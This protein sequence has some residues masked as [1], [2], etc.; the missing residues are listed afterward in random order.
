MATLCRPSM[1]SLNEF[2]SCVVA[3]EGVVAAW[4]RQDTKRRARTWSMP[5]THGRLFGAGRRQAA[6]HMSC[7]WRKANA[8]ISCKSKRAWQGERQSST[9][10]ASEQRPGLA[11]EGWGR[12]HV[13]HSSK[14]NDDVSCGTEF[15]RRQQHLWYQWDECRGIATVQSWLEEGGPS[16]QHDKENANHNLRRPEWRTGE[17]ENR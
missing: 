10:T 11:Q 2:L 9:S 4:Q 14:Y 6:A 5:K 8:N 3:E 17:Q 12:Q 1:G 15:E 7:Q 16:P 13:G